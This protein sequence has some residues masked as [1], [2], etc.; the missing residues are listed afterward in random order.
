MPRRGRDKPDLR[1]IGFVARGWI[2]PVTSN[3]QEGMFDA[4]GGK[5]GP[6]HELT[7]APT[8]GGVSGVR[9]IPWK[10]ISSI[11]LMPRD[12]LPEAALRAHAALF[13]WPGLTDPYVVVGWLTSCHGIPKSDLFA[14]VPIVAARTSAEWFD[15]LQHKGVTIAKPSGA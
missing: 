1:D 12:D 2:E 5:T 9:H 7:F 8:G 4:Q 13:A 3:W 14:L 15:L 6:S 11:R 10:D